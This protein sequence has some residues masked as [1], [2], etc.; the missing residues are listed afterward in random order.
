MKDKT[1]KNLAQSIELIRV[2]DS[3]TSVQGLAIFLAISQN[4]G[5]GF[6][7][8]ADQLNIAQ[9]ALSRQ[10][11]SLGERGRRDKPGLG[12]VVREGDPQDYRRKVVRLTAKGRRVRDQMLAQLG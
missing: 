2:M 4:D 12:L 1:L 9:S 10:I 11:S 8:L 5:I 7:T 3:E 6:G